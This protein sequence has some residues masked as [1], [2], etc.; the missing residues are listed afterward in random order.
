M[1]RSLES[2]EDRTAT[3]QAEAA[4][5]RQRRVKSG[6]HTGIALRSRMSEIHYLG[7]LNRT[8]RIVAEQALVILEKKTQRLGSLH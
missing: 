5:R 7:E 2:S 1:R 3:L 6:E 4:R 8:F